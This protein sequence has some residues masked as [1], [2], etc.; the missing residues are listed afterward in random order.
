MLNEVADGDDTLRI[1]ATGTMHSLGKGASVDLRRR[2]GEW[3]LLPTA[4]EVL[5]AVPAQGSRQI[6]LCGE[7]RTPG[8]LSD[9]LAL[10]AQ[11]TWKGELV[12]RTQKHT[13]SIFLEG[14]SVISVLTTEPKER[15]G[16][17]MLRFG[18]MESRAELEGLIALADKQGKRLGEVAVESGTVSTDALYPIMN[19]QVEEVVFGAIGEENATFCFLDGFED[20][21]A[22][23]FTMPA[24]SAMGL[25]MESA[26][27]ADELKFFREK[28]PSR[29]HIPSR[30]DVG[31]RQPQEKSLLRVLELIDGKISVAELGDALS[32]VE[33]EVTRAVYQLLSSGFIKLKAPTPTGTE[34]IVETFNPAL[35]AIHDACDSSGRGGGLRM[36]LSRFATGS[37]MYD[38]L[39]MGAGPLQ[40]GTFKAE[41]IATNIGALAGQ[42]Q[43]QWLMQLMS[44]YV[45]FALF[46]AESLISREVHTELVTR[47]GEMLKGV[48]PHSNQSP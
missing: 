37:G 41:R 42:D 27:R 47:V 7:V 2:A 16:E 18:I 35:A 3:R 1:D 5:I 14:G 15:L 8:I 30:V 13:R 26:R 10:A 21:P 34:A 44:D 19:R 43:D 40:A 23:R 33:F 46:Q 25:L 11:A 12:V 17:L 28:V 45:G 36:G 38:A 22:K 24:M 4:K 48:L 29:K 9:V 32:I 20:Y 31:A 6:R 39:F